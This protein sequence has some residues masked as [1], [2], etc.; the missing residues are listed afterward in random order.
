MQ[1]GDFLMCKKDYY[2]D[3]TTNRV[4]IKSVHIFRKP[5]FKQ[6]RKYRIDNIITLD[7]SNSGSTINSNTDKNLSSTYFIKNEYCNNFLISKYFHDT[8]STRKEKLNII[9]KISK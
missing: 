7:I 3:K 6:N 5:F 4:G 1:V 2:C 8:K 9:N